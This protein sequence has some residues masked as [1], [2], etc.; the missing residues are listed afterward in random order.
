MFFIPWKTQKELFVWWSI[1]HQLFFSWS[2]RHFA[3]VRKIGPIQSFCLKISDRFFGYRLDCPTSTASQCL[4]L[5]SVVRISCWTWDKVVCMIEMSNE[6]LPEVIKY[7]SS[8]SLMYFHARVHKSEVREFLP[9]SSCF[10][11]I[12]TNGF[13]FGWINSQMT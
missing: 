10:A 2:S 9:F 7:W 1:H 4:V 5:G 6:S 12:R 8:T 11:F 13:M 3:K